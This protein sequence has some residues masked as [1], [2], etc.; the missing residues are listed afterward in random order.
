MCAVAFIP[1]GISTHCLYECSVVLLTLL[2]GSRV[3]WLGVG[4]GRGVELFLEAR[5]TCGMVSYL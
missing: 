2:F 1:F 4:H 3:T 5:L